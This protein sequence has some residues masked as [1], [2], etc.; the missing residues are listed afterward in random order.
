M[1]AESKI[2]WTDEPRLV[3]KVWRIL[4]WVGLVL[5]LFALPADAI[6]ADWSSVW[7]D[8]VV[9]CAFVYVLRLEHTLDSWRPFVPLQMQRKRP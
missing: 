2:E 1:S 4:L 7:H 8:A 9:V 3:D 5:W 6:R